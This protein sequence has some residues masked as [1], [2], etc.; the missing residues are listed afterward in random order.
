MYPRPEARPARNT[1]NETGIEELDDNGACLDPLVL[2]GCGHTRGRNTRLVSLF[3]L[4]PPVSP[5][6]TPPYRGGPN[7][8]LLLLRGRAGTSSDQDGRTGSPSEVEGA[9]DPPLLGLCVLSQVHTEVV[10]LR[11]FVLAV[12]PSRP[13]LS[14]WG[15]ERTGLN[16]LSSST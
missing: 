5:L 15:E 14:S 8:S 10:C 4:R 11:P 3:R 12:T 1:I 7:P 16:S 9:V 2:G 13:R 6:P